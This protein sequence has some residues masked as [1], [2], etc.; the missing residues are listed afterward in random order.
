LRGLAD[1]AASRRPRQ[2]R[3]MMSNASPAH[4]VTRSQ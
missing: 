1:H 2:M 3:M 4:T